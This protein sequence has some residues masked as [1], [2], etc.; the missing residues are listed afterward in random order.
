MSVEQFKTLHNF[1]IDGAKIIFGSLVVGVFVPQ[2]SGEIPWLMF[3]AGVLLTT[4]FLG[5]ALFL[6]HKISKS[7]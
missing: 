6:S 3:I 4:A 2:T 5:V 7:V 1:I